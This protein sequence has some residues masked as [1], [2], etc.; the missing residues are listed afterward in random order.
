M[1][2]QLAELMILQKSMDENTM[3][4]RGIA[5]YPESNMK[6]ALFVELGEMINSFPSKF[7]HWEKEPHDNRA[8]GLI[9]YADALHFT[10]SLLSRLNIDPIE[11]IETVNDADIYNEC[12]EIKWTSLEMYLEAIIDDLSNDDYIEL[13]FDVFALG[14]EYGFKWEEIYNT[15]KVCN[16]IN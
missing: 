12:S 16:T 13:L 14:N 8:K 4:E 6:V 1:I 5:D 9:E 11:M 7:K 3:K 15:Y 2:E 10:L